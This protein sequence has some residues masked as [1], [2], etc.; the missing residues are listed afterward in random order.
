MIIIIIIISLIIII[1]RYY[2]HDYHHYVYI[3]ILIITIIIIIITIIICRDLCLQT[4]DEEH[5]CISLL[6]DYH[7]F[8]SLN[9]IWRALPHLWS[10]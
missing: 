1:R 10:M 6:F 2:Y 5:C 9:I 7:N 4:P 8:V 3:I